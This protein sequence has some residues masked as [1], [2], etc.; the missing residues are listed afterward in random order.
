MGIIRVQYKRNL[1]G[2]PSFGKWAIYSGAW[3]ETS[4]TTAD[5]F[6]TTLLQRLF[7]G[8]P[9]SGTSGAE[10]GN[11]VFNTTSGAARITCWSW[12]GSLTQ[13]QAV[14]VSIPTFTPT[15]PVLLPSQAAIAV[16]YRRPITTVPQNGRSR[17]FIGPLHVA[18]AALDTSAHGRGLVLTSGAVSNIKDCALGCITRLRDTHGWT[19]QVKSGA[20]GSE[21]FAAADEIYVD[22]VLD[23][24][25]SRRS[26]EVHQA[27]ES[28]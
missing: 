16:G 2:P 12:A 27:R 9:Y 10:I 25:R 1:T 19:L 18:A 4:D 28:F 14:N 6:V 3:F 22:D 11:S 7:L 21:T 8:L 17:F 24:Q 5:G 23:V 13:T 26:W 20:A 15:S